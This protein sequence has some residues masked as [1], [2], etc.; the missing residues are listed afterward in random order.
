MKAYL[1]NNEH[2]W[3]SVL[4]KLFKIGCRWAYNEKYEPALS[5]NEYYKFGRESKEFP[6]IVVSDNDK[7]LHYCSIEFLINA[8]PV[9]Y[10]KMIRREK[11]KKIGK[12]NCER[13]W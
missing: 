11:L 6:I 4:D 5:F 7:I 13:F 8:F 9:E 12:L 2:D 10:N 1:V 3:V